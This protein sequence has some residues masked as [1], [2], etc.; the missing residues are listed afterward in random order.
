M[1]ASILN[2]FSISRD[3]ASTALSHQLPHVETDPKMGEEEPKYYTLFGPEGYNRTF[4]KSPPPVST[5]LLE[6]GFSTAVNITMIP[7]IVNKLYFTKDGSSYKKNALINHTS[8][9]DAHESWAN[10]NPGYEIRYFDLLAA[11]GYLQNYFHPL[12][13][14][15]FDCIEA[16][17]G[18]T[19]FFRAALLY[20][21]GGFHSDFKQ[22]CLVPN[23]LDEIRN[24]AD[25][26]VSLDKGTRYGER[27]NCAQTAFVGSVPRHPIIAKFLEL[28]MINV[29]K[30]AYTRNVLDMTGPCLFGNAVRSYWKNFNGKESSWPIYQGY[31]FR[32]RGQDIILHKCDGCSMSQEWSN[33]NNYDELYK[34]K[35]YYCQDAASIF[36]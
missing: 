23:I 10:L 33:G 6:D 4:K 15:T 27:N 21:D 25:F 32:W 28:I 2:A 3:Q 1:F 36:G 5:W 19:N 29:Q 31:H 17:S 24:T 34:T 35:N 26:F 11:R 9:L 8:L 13:L 22:K 7:R 14:R 20:R 16:F 12:F 30:A 18:K